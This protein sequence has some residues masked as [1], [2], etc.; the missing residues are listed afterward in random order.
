LGEWPG[1]AGGPP[2]PGGERKQCDAY[3]ELDCASPDE[4]EEQEDQGERSD[5]ES[6]PFE[7]LHRCVLVELM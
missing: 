4:P 3:G 2:D 1:A 7:V 5:R 6:D